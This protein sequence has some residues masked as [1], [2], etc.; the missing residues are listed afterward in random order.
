MEA[1]LERGWLG[2]AGARERRQFSWRAVVWALVYPERGQ[3]TI[4]T[5]PGMML[6]GLALGIGTAA[7]NSSSNILFITLSL[8]LSGLVLSGVWSWI[9][10]RGVA[11]R[12]RVPGPWRA[13]QAGTVLVETAKPRA[14]LPSYGLGFEV[15]ARAVEPPERQRAEATLRAGGREVRAILTRAEGS[16]ARARLPLRGRLAPGQTAVLEWPCT[17]ERRGCLR[18]ELLAVGSLFPFGFLRKEMAGGARQEVTVW[19]ATIPYVR[20]GA[21]P[22]RRGAG[23]QRARWSGGGSDLVALR[24]YTMGDSH[25]L[26]HWK[27]S[28]RTGRLLVRQCAAEVSAGCVLWFDA[29]GARWPRAGQFETGVSLAATLAEDL[30]RVGSLAAV[31]LA[32]EAPRP[33]RSVRDLEAF[34]DRLAVV[35]PTDGEGGATASVV[36]RR[37][38]IT[39][40]PEGPSGVV[41]LLDGVRWAAA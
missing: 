40:A 9:N 38:L 32:A 3:R 14:R 27:A 18:V 7:Y 19:P 8:L 39:L 2:P 10:F 25:R 1:E 41:A 17:P 23:P 37:H 26:I 30:F 21:T 11:W 29:D 13:G 28:A 15:V 4:P 6:I 12:L 5:V 16:L 31:A 33:V 22:G 34:L 20:F 36:G 35:V 24:R